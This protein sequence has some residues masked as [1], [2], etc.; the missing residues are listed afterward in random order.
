MAPRGKKNDDWGGYGSKQAYVDAIKS[1]KVKTQTMAGGN[2]RSTLVAAATRLATP[3]R[4]TARNIGSWAAEASDEV[5]TYVARGPRTSKVSG[6][7]YTPKGVFQG[8]DVFVSKPAVSAKK[9]AAVQKG[10]QTRAANI[11]AGQVRSSARASV[12]AGTFGAVGGA[13]AATEGVRVVKENVQVVK[14][15]VK[16]ARGGGT[17]KK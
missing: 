15:V 7:V 10:L 11:R 16:K 13:Y 1:G 6:D 14:K 9:A 5:G 17:K 8:K 3:I 12:L 2:L 4:N